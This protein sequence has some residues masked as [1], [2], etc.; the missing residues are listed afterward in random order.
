MSAGRIT[1]RC[2]LA[3]SNLMLPNKIGKWE[4]VVVAGFFRAKVIGSRAVFKIGWIGYNAVEFDLQI[5]Q[6]PEK[7]CESLQSD[8]S[9]ANYGC[10]LKLPCRRIYRFRQLLF[11][12]SE[13]CAIIRAISPVPV[14]TSRMVFASWIPAHAPSNTPSIPTFIA[15]Y[16]CTTVN[17]LNL[18]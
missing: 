12:H 3:W 11:L 6:I 14:P 13:L 7:L 16:S 18:K 5:A 10:S 2:P 8:L 15:E 1:E 4:L 17:C 9:M